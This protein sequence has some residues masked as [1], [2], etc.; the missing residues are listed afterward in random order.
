MS[1]LPIQPLKRLS[2]TAVSAFNSPVALVVY[3]ACAPSGNQ[4]STSHRTWSTQK[5]DAWCWLDGRGMEDA[6]PQ[7]WQAAVD[8]AV[9]QVNEVSDVTV[10]PHYEDDFMVWFEVTARAGGTR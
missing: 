7:D 10:V 5:F 2:M 8:R 4:G 3:T 9:K 1:T 6:L